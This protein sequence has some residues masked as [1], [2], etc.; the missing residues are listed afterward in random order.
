MNLNRAG[1]LVIAS[2]L[3]SASACA[4][5]NAQSSYTLYGSIDESIG[6]VTNTKGGRA[7][8]MGPIAVPDQF[9]F[10]GSEDLGGGTNAIFRLK[11]GYFSN[12][13]SF[14]TAALPSLAPSSTSSQASLRFGV[15]HFF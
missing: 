15:Q 13:G 10:K 4:D 2:V 3:A 5:A 14:T 7:A 11:N 1:T 6:Y 9:G 8:V 12:T